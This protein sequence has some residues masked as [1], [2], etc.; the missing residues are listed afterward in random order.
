MKKKTDIDIVKF[1][2]DNSFKNFHELIGSQILPFVLL[3]QKKRSI[4]ERP[5]GNII[6]DAQLCFLYTQAQHNFFMEMYFIYLIVTQINE[7]TNGVIK[8]NKGGKTKKN[9]KNKK[10]TKRKLKRRKNQKG[11]N[12][13]QSVLIISALLLLLLLKI[14]T[15]R[16]FEETE[17]GIGAFKFSDIPILDPDNLDA[18]KEF[19]EK[20]G[21][22]K[23]LPQVK[24]FQSAKLPE[25]FNVDTETSGLLSN[26][27]ST[28]A[29]LNSFNEKVIKKAGEIYNN[30]MR[31]AQESLEELCNK[32]IVDKSTNLS[33]IELGTLYMQI[34]EEKKEERSNYLAMTQ[35]NY[36]KQVEKEVHESMPPQEI[37]FVESA[38]YVA[39]AAAN[40]FASSKEVTEIKNIE[41][42]IES[43][44][45][46]S[47]TINARIDN[48]LSEVIEEANLNFTDSIKKDSFYNAD[49]LITESQNRRLYLENICYSLKE[50]LLVYNKTEGILHFQTFPYSREM[51]KVLL[52]N[53]LTYTKGQIRY[54]E[55]DN[56]G[57]KMEKQIELAEYLQTVFDKSDAIYRK[58]IKDGHKGETLNG[59]MSKIGQA[60]DKVDELIKIGVSGNPNER[61]EAEE[62]IKE[63]DAK[64]EIEFMEKDTRARKRRIDIE[65]NEEFLQDYIRGMKSY[66][67][68]VGVPLWNVYEG[69]KNMAQDELKDWIMF[70]LLWGGGGFI[71]ACSC[72][73]MGRK[74]LFGSISPQYQNYP[75]QNNQQLL[76][77]SQQLQLENQ[78][79]RLENQQ[80]LSQSQQ[81]EIQQ[82]RLENQQLRSQ[83]EQSRLALPPSV[84]EPQSRW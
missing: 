63:Q 41:Q 50:P 81:Q 13:M 75:Q 52:K 43:D 58:A 12:S 32:V 28:D 3:E 45:M 61:L 54:A 30:H 9:K 36:I 53:I 38:S 79:L 55:T 66:S 20:F 29:K 46:A 1:I 24:S 37:T 18:M 67:D 42:K 27:F 7:A 16:A 19:T 21:Q 34:N 64:E 2:T 15:N 73:W 82:L 80:L 22:M 17:D 76:S 51:V 26:F 83:Q 84:Q 14:Q 4:L 60:I 78:Q 48:E 72:F 74:Y 68:Y 49:K 5:N 10:K 56:D 25:I 57:Y 47:L 39:S 77:P 23:N 35:D 11:G 71:V 69:T 31:R 44:E 62:R 65:N 70:I 59:F 33:P 8:F 40:Y 6:I